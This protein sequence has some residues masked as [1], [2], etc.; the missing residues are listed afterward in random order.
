MAVDSLRSLASAECASAK[1]FCRRAQA[2]NDTS[3]IN[4]LKPIICCEFAANTSPL[5]VK[6][7]CV[8]T[9]CAA[10]STRVACPGGSRERERDRQTER[11]RERER[12]VP[13]KHNPIFYLW[14]TGSP[15]ARPL[16]DTQEVSTT[17]KPSEAQVS[18]TSPLT[19]RAGRGQQGLVAGCGVTLVTSGCNYQF[20][21][22]CFLFMNSPPSPL[23]FPISQ[24]PQ[25]S[26]RFPQ[27]RSECRGAWHRLSARPAA[28]PSLSSTGTRRA[29]RSTPSVSRWLSQCSTVTSHCSS[30]RNAKQ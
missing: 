21:C 3:G 14:P 30:M 11:E 5:P 8:M 4:T 6:H 17:H 16:D 23:F 20:S 15:S 19:A 7:S 22:L 13:L 2:Q 18:L 28:V 1:A 24:L 25:S 12:D 10:C 29:R 9:A 26:P 27:T